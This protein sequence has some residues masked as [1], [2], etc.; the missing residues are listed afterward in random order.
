MQQHSRRAF[1]R[2]LAGAALVTALQ[3]ASPVSVAEDNN[4]DDDEEEDPR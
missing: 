4:T 3:T 1:V 2:A